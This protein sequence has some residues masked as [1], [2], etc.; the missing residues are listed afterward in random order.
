MIVLALCLVTLV[1]VSVRTETTREE[2]TS[3]RIRVVKH[4][5][6]VTRALV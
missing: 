2:V 5:Y 6:D 3:I 4:F 1:I